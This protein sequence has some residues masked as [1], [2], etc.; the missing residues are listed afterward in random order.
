[1][2]EFWIH[3]VKNAGNKVKTAEL[4]W[5]T[6]SIACYLIHFIELMKEL[7]TTKLA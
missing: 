5:I 1:M 6:R 3:T 7:N 4:A 2:L